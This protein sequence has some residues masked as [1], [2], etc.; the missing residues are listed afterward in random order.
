MGHWQLSLESALTLSACDRA[1]KRRKKKLIHC[2]LNT[3][4]GTLTAPACKDLSTSWDSCPSLTNVKT[5]KDMSW[6][7]SGLAR[8]ASLPVCAGSK[9]RSWPIFR[10]FQFKQTPHSKCSLE[11][12]FWLTVLFLFLGLVL[13]KSKLLHFWCLSLPCSLLG[14]HWAGHYNH[15]GNCC[16]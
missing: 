12:F 4:R 2:I 8:S 5:G 11:V 9:L 3:H 7:E 13:L 14:C 15:T 6:E 1:G 10:Q 16:G